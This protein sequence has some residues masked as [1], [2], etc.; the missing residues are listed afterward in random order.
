MKPADK[1][2]F[3]RLALWQLFGLNIER[4]ASGE[5]YAGRVA[6]GTVTL[7]RVDHRTWDG[8]TLKEVILWPWQFSWTMP[9]A[10]KAYYERAVWIASNWVEAYRTMTALQDCCLIAIGMMSRDIPRDP[11]VAAAHCCQ[12]LT[13][14]LRASMDQAWQDERDP[15]KKERINGKRW[16]RTMRHIKTVGAH[17]FYA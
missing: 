2:I 10:D 15:A 14:H 11:D 8:R 13:G 3:E 16:W 1:P 12:Y 9:E 6:V 7:E 5:P 17:E 4:E